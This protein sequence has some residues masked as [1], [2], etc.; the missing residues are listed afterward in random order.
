MGGVGVCE[1]PQLAAHDAEHS[2]P[3]QLQGLRPLPC[4]V[5]QRQPQEEGQLSPPSA[6][7]VPEPD[8]PRLREPHTAHAHGRRVTLH[9]LGATAPGSK[10]G[11]RANPEPSARRPDEPSTPTPRPGWTAATDPHRGARHTCS[12]RLQPR[13]WPD[14]RPLHDRGFCRRH[15][16]LH[17]SSVEA[18]VASPVTRGTCPREDGRRPLV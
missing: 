7:A 3:G 9:T 13:A 15:T 12:S 2:V 8:W 10:A 11:S 17:S 18:P 16:R 1:G 14:T 5:P 6:V 4:P